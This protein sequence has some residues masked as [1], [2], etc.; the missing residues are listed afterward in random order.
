MMTRDGGAKPELL[1]SKIKP[2]HHLVVFIKRD[3]KPVEDAKVEIWYK[4]ASSKKSM[5][6][7]LPVTR[8]HITDKSLATTHYGNNVRLS[9][10]KYEAQVTVDKNSPVLF[11]FNLLK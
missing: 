10:G 8:M 2:N 6:K 4:K 11:H 5:W 1:N 7:K 9:P 3:G